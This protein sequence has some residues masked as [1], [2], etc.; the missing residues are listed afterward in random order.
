MNNQSES[1]LTLAAADVTARREAIRVEIEALEKVL[2]KKMR[3]YVEDLPEAQ[4]AML[5]AD[6]HTILSLGPEQRS[7]AQKQK[8]SNTF[9]KRSKE[10]KGDFDRLGALKKQFP[11]A[12]TTLVLKELAKPRETYVHIGGDFTRNG[13]KVGPGVPAVLPPLPAIANRLP[14]RLDL[15]Q[16]L[17]AHN[18]PLTARVEVNR[19]WQGYFGLGIV[20]TENDFGT[21]GSPP[22][23]P[24]LL[25]WLAVEFMDGGWSM[26]QMH[27]LIVTSATYRQSSRSRTELAEIDPMNRLLARQNR[28]R[29]DAEVVRDNALAV[30]GLLNRTVGGP[31]VYPPQPQGVYQFT[32]VNRSWNT[33]VGPDRYRRG[34]YVFFQRSAPYPALTVFDAPDANSTCTRRVRSNTPLQ[35]LTLLN[36]AAYLELARGLGE[37]LIREG[38]A[39]D[40]PRLQFA[41]KLCLA[42]QPH[43]AELKRLSDFLARQREEF[44]AAPAEA[45]ALLLAAAGGNLAPADN[46]VEIAAWI[47]VARVLLNLD[48]F[49]TRE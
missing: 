18:N 16:W 15:A 4:H 43:A 2:N 37:R 21:Q 27:R 6:I 28:L 13:E 41:F 46:A 1:T 48:E 22:T 38:P 3:K 29:L 31:S 32:Q 7:D 23:H 9:G 33:S 20:E 36:D 14:N 25:D 8:L 45:Q 10:L 40:E 30:S 17:V 49:I 26:K 19:L 42:R 44:R 24:E 12:P 34:L 5:D 35:A 47:A 39:G 11:K